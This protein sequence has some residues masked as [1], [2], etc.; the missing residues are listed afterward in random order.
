M[1]ARAG[2]SAAFV[3]L[4]LPR[5]QL[6]PVIDRLAS[7]PSPVPLP[8]GNR[9]SLAEAFSDTRHDDTSSAN[10]SRSG[11]LCGHGRGRA[12]EHVAAASPTVMSLFARISAR[13][14]SDRRVLEDH[15]EWGIASAP[16]RSGIDGSI[17]VNLD[18]ARSHEE[19]NQERSTHPIEIIGT[20]GSRSS[21][22]IPRPDCD[23]AWI[24]EHCLACWWSLN[25][26]STSESVRA[27]GESAPVSP[28]RS[29]SSWTTS[30]RHS[31]S[32]SSFAASMR[33]GHARS[34]WPSQPLARRPGV[35]A[36]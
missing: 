14:T 9:R 5:D 36:G 1:P 28:T 8:F 17:C 31:S 11:G 32:A 23:H 30:R 16:R 25:C 4:V 21:S 24:S 2:E 6:Q 22:R 29:V 34:M 3:A 7:I 27:A 18:L 35:K 13:P 15:Q 20:R 26:P 10:T 12:E 33:A 19:R